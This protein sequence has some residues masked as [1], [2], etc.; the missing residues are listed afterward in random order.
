[1]NTESTREKVFGLLK[2]SGDIIP[3]SPQ[4]QSH[5][6]VQQILQYLKE[7]SRYVVGLQEIEDYQLAKTLLKEELGRKKNKEEIAVLYQ[8][9]ASVT[10]SATYLAIRDHVP[11]DLESHFNNLKDYL[12]RFRSFVRKYYRKFR[13]A[14]VH[15]LKATDFKN[16][17]LNITT[18]V[19]QILQSLSLYYRGT[20]E[21]VENCTPKIRTILEDFD[22]PR[23][24][25]ELRA[26][27][28]LIGAG[29][30]INN[31][32]FNDEKLKE[33]AR[34]FK[35]HV[36]TET[37]NM[38]R[39]WDLNKFLEEDM[40]DFSDRIDDIFKDLK[41]NDTLI[42]DKLSA[43]PHTLI[44]NLEFRQVWETYQR[45]LDSKWK[46]SVKG[47]RFVDEICGYFKRQFNKYISENNGEE[48][49][50]GWT[51]P[52]LTQ[53]M[54]HP[55][56]VDAIDDDGSGYI[57]VQEFNA[58]LKQK[59]EH[60]ST[61]EQFVFWAVGWQQVMLLLQVADLL[62][63][64]TKIAKTAKTGS[65]EEDEKNFI[66]YYL[67]CLSMI[68]ELIS[69]YDVSGYKRYFATDLQ[70]Y[71]SLKM[72]NLTNDYQN[73]SKS[74][75]DNFIQSDA[76]PLEERE[77]LAS[78]QSEFDSRA[79]VWIIPF[80]AA[81]LEQH[82]QEMSG[83]MPIGEDGWYSMFYT[84]ST[85]LVELN[86]RMHS[87]ERRWSVQKIN[88]FLQA[89]SFSGGILS[90][91][92]SAVH[93]ST[94][95]RFQNAYELLKKREAEEY[96]SDTE[97]DSD[98]V[99]VQTTEIAEIRSLRAS[100]SELQSSVAEL[101][102]MMQRILLKIDGA[103]G[104][105]NTTSNTNHGQE[106]QDDD[107]DDDDEQPNRGSGNRSTVTGNGFSGGYAANVTREEDYNHNQD[108]NSSEEN[109]D[110]ASDQEGD[111]SENSGYED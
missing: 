1:M 4:V 66:D 8:L 93:D 21:H 70:E 55:H 6:R 35:E 9:F 100:V 67:M 81:V 18:D 43:G 96:N 28:I 97:E 88:Q 26:Q 42:I 5:Q 86:I 108:G 75:F 24:R 102:I 76:Y 17:L 62:D 46:T 79:E 77:D 48:H 57:S 30:N 32:V 71:Y 7:A 45:F 103:G 52:V 89:M 53:I 85:L 104:D 84:L 68:E 69:W 87:L 13:L 61:P 14:V 60:W 25:D 101:T 92:Y 34:I 10:F 54:F 65:T 44:E 16:V 90:A 109:E 51:I 59:P 2:K 47:R 91:W 29:G 83:E 72:V 38:L 73:F 33:I 80:L 37:K 39:N 3:R 56:I 105:A 12:K 106:R 40:E 58:F 23:T 78:L 49:K 22:D 31:V 19:D 107:D 11:D 15:F 99:N 36:T 74:L 98:N 27:D 94:N 64:V 41:N 82:K 20:A 110:G 111:D 63:E 50:D 95:K